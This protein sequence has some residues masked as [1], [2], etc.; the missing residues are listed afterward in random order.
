MLRQQHD[1]IIK[2][3]CI[4][5]PLFSSSVNASFPS[6]TSAILS[7][8]KLAQP[9]E[10]FV[11][12]PSHPR[13]ASLSLMSQ[14]HLHLF[15]EERKSRLFD[16]LT[17]GQDTSFKHHHLSQS[18]KGKKE[19]CHMLR[20]KKGSEVTGKIPEVH[21]HH[22]VQTD[23]CRDGKSRHATI[24]SEGSPLKQKYSSTLNLEYTQI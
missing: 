13:N 12:S 14:S 16:K 9:Q 11:W 4:L 15:T 24:I 3:N 23:Q 22:S 10:N 6:K 21:H 7:N 20:G 8:L 19:E 18:N 1:S 2:T 5:F 17:L